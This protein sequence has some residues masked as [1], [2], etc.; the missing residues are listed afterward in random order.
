MI[1]KDN[2]MVIMVFVLCLGGF[3]VGMTI[4]TNLNGNMVLKVKQM[5]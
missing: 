1:M 2:L 5:I 4:S 3:L